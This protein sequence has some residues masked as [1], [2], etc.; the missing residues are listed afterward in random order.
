MRRAALHERAAALDEDDVAPAAV[1][2]PDALP[3]PEDPEA[4]RLVQG[5]AGGV[6]GEDAGLDGPDPGGLGGGDQRVQERMAD[7]VAAGAGMDV[8]RMFDN[9]GVD[10]AA[11]YSRGSHPARDLASCGGDEPVTRQAGRGEVRPA[12]RA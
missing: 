8:N 12:G 6:L 11:G 4:C 10:A 2:L 7:A 3:D 5:Q 9:P 1:M